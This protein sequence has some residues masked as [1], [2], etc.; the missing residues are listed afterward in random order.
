MSLQRLKLPSASYFLLQAAGIDDGANK[1]G[2]LFVGKVSLKHIYE[3]AKVCT[4]CTYATVAST[5]LKKV[6]LLADM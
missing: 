4:P 5:A 1:P 3:I 2:E 6:L